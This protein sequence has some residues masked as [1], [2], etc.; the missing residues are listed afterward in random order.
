M[1]R[2][3]LTCL[4]GSLLLALILSLPAAAADSPKIA[5]N[6]VANDIAVCACGKIFVPDATTEYLS[7]N[8][9]QYACCT[10]ACHEMAMKDP[11]ARGEAG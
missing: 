3:R 11:V 5:V 10:H 6:Q 7:A 1:N 4:A 9:K 8:G 2:F